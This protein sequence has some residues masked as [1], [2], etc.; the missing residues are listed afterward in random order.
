MKS[1]RLPVTAGCVVDS[2]FVTKNAHRLVGSGGSRVRR[3]GIHRAGIRRARPRKFAAAVALSAQKQSPK[4]LPK[5]PFDLAQMRAC[6][7]S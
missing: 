6:N 5:L 7:I 2:S 3:A 1:E 4:F